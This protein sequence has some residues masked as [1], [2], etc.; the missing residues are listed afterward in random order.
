MHLILAFSLWTGGPTAQPGDR[1]FG[2]DKLFHFAASALIQSATHSAL[3]SRGASY[4]T[5]SR[6][7]AGVTVAAGVGKELWDLRRRD[8]FSV[9]DLAWDGIGGVTA[10][11]AMRQ[12]DR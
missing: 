9:R 4:A 11:V 3:R 12:L 8:D 10:A 7:A 1:W 6:A 5:A 2:R